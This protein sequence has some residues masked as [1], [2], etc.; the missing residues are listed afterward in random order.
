VTGAGWV[1]TVAGG[2]RLHLRVIPRAGQNA[3]LGPRD[4]RLR[5]RVAAPP[6]EDQANQ[7]LISFLAKEFRVGKTHVQLIRGERSR[8]KSVF[9]R[10]P[11]ILPHWCTV[12]LPAQQPE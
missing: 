5:V 4:G 3:I 12:L 9:I 6:V 2:V 8:E 7:R 1:E 10:N 11:R